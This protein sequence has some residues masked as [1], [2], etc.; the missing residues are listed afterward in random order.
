MRITG[1]IAKGRVLSSF[2]GRGIRPTSEKVRE[3]IFNVVGQDLSGRAVLDL[4]A[5]TG[6]LSLEALSRGAERA[7]MVEVS[8]KAIKVIK[9]NIELCGFP[10]NCTIIRHDIRAGIPVSHPAFGEQVDLV[11]LD[12]PYG[13]GLEEKTLKELSKARIFGPGAEVVV[14]SAKDTVLPTAIGPLEMVFERTY[15]DTKLMVFED[16]ESKY[17]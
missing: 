11:F 5:G 4:F 2:K 9:K 17:G 6:I 15:G 8:H 1:G 3:A 10:E 16:K 13:K 12:P 14:E 7:V